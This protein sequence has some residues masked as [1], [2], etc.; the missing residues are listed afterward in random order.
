ML[1]ILLGKRFQPGEGPIRG[2]LCDCEI[3]AN[4]CL[5]FVS[6][7]S[8][9][10]IICASRDLFCPFQWSRDMV[11]FFEEIQRLDVLPGVH[12]MLNPDEFLSLIPV[13]CTS[14]YFDDFAHSGQHIL[15]RSILLPPLQ[16]VVLSVLYGV[17]EIAHIRQILRLL[18]PHS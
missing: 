10:Q 4:F 5:A 18:A 8:A 16:V 6:S 1:F 13:S 7:S 2:F 17:I 12:P 15:A 14:Q 9:W 3:F 11:P